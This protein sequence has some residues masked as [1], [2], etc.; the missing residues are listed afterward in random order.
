MVERVYA[1]PHH[2]HGLQGLYA[3]RMRGKCVSPIILMVCMV[4]CSSV[5]PENEG[6]I[7]FPHHSHG[8]QGLYATRMRGICISPI[9]SHGLQGALLIC[10]P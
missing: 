8:Q 3:T 5:C 1:F 4:P 9:I 6:V 2:S 10:M 7:A